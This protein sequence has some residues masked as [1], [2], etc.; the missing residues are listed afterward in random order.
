MPKSGSVEE[1]K[2]RAGE[3]T[4]PVSIYIN[5]MILQYK[6]KIL[7]YKMMILQYKMMIL[8]LKMLILH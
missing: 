1:L 4:P 2:M 5:M 7:Q 6:M 8:P 3:Q